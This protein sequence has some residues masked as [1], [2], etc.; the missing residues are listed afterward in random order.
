[1]KPSS[2]SLPAAVTA[3]VTA[4]VL[5]VTTVAQTPQTPATS[6][7]AP[8]QGEHHDHPHAAP[9]NLQVLPKNLTGDQ[10]HEIMDKWEGELG[11]HCSTCHAADPKNIGP[12]GRPRLNYADDSKPEKATARLMYKMTEDIN[13]NYVSKVPNS[14]VPVTCGTCHRGHFGPEP[15]VIPPDDHGPRPP[16][17]Q[18]PTGTTTPH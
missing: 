15:F 4:A 7:P 10:V 6:A 12:N 1:L 14:E 5:A 16:Q 8:P 3:F 18:P 17:A 9:T 13:V 2:L 11:V